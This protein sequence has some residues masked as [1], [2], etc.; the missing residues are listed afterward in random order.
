MRVRVGTKGEFETRLI[1]TDAGAKRQQRPSRL[2]SLP[3]YGSRARGGSQIAITF[4]QPTGKPGI[5]PCASLPIRKSYR[6][7]PV[8]RC[9][10]HS[11][12]NDASIF[13]SSKLQV[14]N[15]RKPEIKKS[16]Q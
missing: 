1:P 12:F 10:P 11:N 6:T 4:H 5:T 2:F 9:T 15:A 13:L 8:L 7:S 16:V 3:A 14:T